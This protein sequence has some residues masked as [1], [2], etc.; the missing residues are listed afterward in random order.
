MTRGRK[1]TVREEERERYR[2]EET[3]IE[4]EERNVEVLGYTPHSTPTAA[5]T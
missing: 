5:N 3:Y 2:E 1:E 4:R